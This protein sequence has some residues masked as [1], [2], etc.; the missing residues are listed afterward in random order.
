[1]R[2]DTRSDGYSSLQLKAAELETYR[3]LIGRLPVTMRPSLNQQLNGWEELFPYEQKRFAVFLRGI[4]EFDPAA[5]D[6]L[7]QPL[8]TLEMK[9]GVAHWNFSE[10]G[11]TLE[12]ASMLERSE[13]YA[14]WRREVQRIFAALDKAAD[15]SLARP[16]G[17]PRL[18]L[19]ILPETLPVAPLENWEPWS[20]HGQAI[21]IDGDA[22]RLCELIMK[23]Q[24]G[25]P[26]IT[27]LLA[28]QGDR[29]SSDIWLIDAEKKLDG[30]PPE[31]VA[32]VA[33]SL[34]YSDLKPF[35]DQLLAEVNAVPKSIEATDRIL[36]A[37]RQKNRD[38]EW[39]VDQPGQARLRSF[40]VN[41]FLSGNGAFI[42]SNAF[43][44]WAASEAFRR[45]RP[46]VIVARFGLRSK[47][48]PFTGIAIFENQQRISTLPDADD[49]EGSAMDALI[50][51][52][53][54]WLAASRYPEKENTCCICIS[55]SRNAAYIL[56]ASK[57]KTEWRPERPAT[58]E[59]ISQWAAQQFSS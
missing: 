44:E 13:Y 54:V 53:Y 37:I 59:E 5:F 29:E 50:L 33:N 17:L 39:P 3:R 42:F 57:G 24:P 10:G 11:D 38:D 30:L 58:P 34:S 47:P 51:A 32:T 40:A 23:G 46:R 25:Q 19:L 26:G 55:E 43:V 36:A 7:V 31:K 28:S 9:M 27:E 49:P 8:K 16:D 4:E 1:M 14:E 56:S 45:V 52:R 35:R 21:K 12:N 41:L 15:G 20:E 6:A 22:K 48:K 18:I 2:L